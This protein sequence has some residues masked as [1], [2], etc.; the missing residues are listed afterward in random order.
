M[1]ARLGF[2]RRFFANPV[3]WLAAGIFVV[4][5]ASVVRADRHYSY[6]CALAAP[7]HIALINDDDYFVQPTDTIAY[8]AC[9]GRIPVRWKDL[10]PLADCSPGGVP[11]YSDGSIAMIIQKCQKGRSNN[12]WVY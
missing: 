3:T 7:I 12:G 10:W 5:G 6:T 11:R 9:K 8:N 1:L 2:S 4:A